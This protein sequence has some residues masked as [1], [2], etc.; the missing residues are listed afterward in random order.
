MI[1]GKGMPDRSEAK[2]SIEY[3]IRNA[4]YQLSKMWASCQL[5]Y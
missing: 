2:I 3:S 5:H 4:Q 1:I